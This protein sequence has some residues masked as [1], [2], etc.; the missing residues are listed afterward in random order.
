MWVHRRKKMCK[1]NNKSVFDN[2][3]MCAGCGGGVFPDDDSAIDSHGGTVHFLCLGDAEFNYLE[4][5]SLAE[6]KVDYNAEH[7]TRF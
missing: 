3:K 5:A 6:A 4:W 7:G 2:M 1:E